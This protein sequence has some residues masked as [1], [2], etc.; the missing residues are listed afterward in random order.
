MLS[1][2]SHCPACERPVGQTFLPLDH[3]GAL[4]QCRSCGHQVRTRTRVCPNCGAQDP[5]HWPRAARS[6][7]AATVGVAAV[8]VLTLMATSKELPDHAGGRGAV[9]PPETTV[10]V[11]AQPETTATTPAAAPASSATVQPADPA[12]AP[13]TAV[14][15]RPQPPV[16]DSTPGPVAAAP[17]PARPDSSALLSSAL[18]T[19]WTTTWVNVRDEPSDGAPI[20]RVLGPA[21]AVRG[22]AARWGWWAV[23]LGGDSVGYIAG[24]L[25]SSRKPGPD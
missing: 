11:A 13:S 8:V 18:Q 14:S 2:A 25:L 10:T 4:A 17:I 9:V 3:E 19:R 21:T 12:P 7:L 16:A 1:I 15:P 20:L 24:A 22:A 23:R 5:A 6:A